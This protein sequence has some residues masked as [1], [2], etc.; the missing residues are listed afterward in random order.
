[1]KAKSRKPQPSKRRNTLA[2]RIAAEP[3]LER[4]LKLA[5]FGATAFERD[6]PAVELAIEFRIFLGK[7]TRQAIVVRGGRDAWK[8]FRKCAAKAIDDWTPEFFE[9]FA[10]AMRRTTRGEFEPLWSRSEEER[11]KWMEI[12]SAQKV[13][14]RRLARE[15]CAIRYCVPS[16]VR[17]WQ[18]SHRE[19]KTT[20]LDKD[21]LDK[22]AVNVEREFRR[23]RKLLLPPD[24]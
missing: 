21:A 19:I 6:D 22:K 5:W 8:R 12:L 14:I 17:W 13:S 3:D 2:A 23:L 18:L 1:V 10:E 7:D 20:G 24:T 4:K 9:R 16:G 11:F 15:F